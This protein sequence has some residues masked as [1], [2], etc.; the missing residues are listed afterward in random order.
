MLGGDG[1][2]LDAIAG[3]EFSVTSNVGM[4]LGIKLRGGKWGWLLGWYTGVAFTFKQES[5]SSCPRGYEWTMLADRVL[6][7][8]C[9]MMSNSAHVTRDCREH[10]FRSHP[11][12]WRR[13]QTGV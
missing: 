9:S 6:W 13:Y 5:P 1:F 4:G 10:A 2:S 11:K 12:V 7:G 8:F 3:A